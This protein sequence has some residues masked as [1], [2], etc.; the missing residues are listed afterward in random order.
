MSSATQ[1]A[2]TFEHVRAVLSECR[3]LK[4]SAECARIEAI[5]I[6]VN[7]NPKSPPTKCQDT[8]RL[9]YKSQLYFY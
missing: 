4:T 9:T 3:K 6:N 2:I 5:V 7:H 1:V 8:T